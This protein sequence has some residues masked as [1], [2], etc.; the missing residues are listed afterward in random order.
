[1]L[2]LVLSPRA[3]QDI[4]EI[5]HYTAQQWSKKQAE[6]YI[7]QLAEQLELVAVNPNMAIACPEVRIGYYKFR[8]GSHYAFFKLLPDG[9]NVIRIL[10]ERMNFEQ[11][12]N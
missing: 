8:C 3:H 11:H 1:M 4:E 12:I 2:R 5:W 7:R 6:L 9:I 10:H